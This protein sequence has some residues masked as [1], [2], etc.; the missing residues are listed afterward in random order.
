MIGGNRSKRARP[1]AL[2]ALNLE[3]KSAL[4]EA[5]AAATYDG[6]V[7][8]LRLMSE[9]AHTHGALAAVELWHG[10]IHV[11]DLVDCPIPSDRLAHVEPN[12]PAM[13]GSD[14]YPAFVSA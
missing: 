11:D 9:G 4:A 6:D 5:L 1:A 2:N 3:L 8:A 10:G 7:R 12:W 13:T 14:R